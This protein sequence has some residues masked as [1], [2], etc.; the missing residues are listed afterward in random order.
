MYKS[1]ILLEEMDQ[2]IQSLTEFK[3]S[4][5]KHLLNVINLLE[6]NEIKSNKILSSLKNIKDT[7]VDF[8]LIEDG[9]KKALSKKGDI[10]ENCE[11]YFNSVSKSLNKI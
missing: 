5:E 4:K 9:L 1:F 10:T 3:M 8:K 2:M 11:F 7:D 6:N